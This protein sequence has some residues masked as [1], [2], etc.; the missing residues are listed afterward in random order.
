VDYE[1]DEDAHES[2][3]R[4]D[5]PSSDAGSVSSGSALA[6]L[7]LCCLAFAS[8]SWLRTPHLNLSRRLNTTCAVSQQGVLPHIVRSIPLLPMLLNDDFLRL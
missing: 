7:L 8:C 2:P 3:P 6:R 4:P 5:T 1:D